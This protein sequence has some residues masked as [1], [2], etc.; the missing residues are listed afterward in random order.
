MVF[1]RNRAS[2]V[3]QTH[4]RMEEDL[5]IDDSDCTIH[6]LMMYF[7]GQS[8]RKYIINPRMVQPRYTLRSHSTAQQWFYCIA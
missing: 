7:G 8:S 4:A 2:F 6:G 3:E 5:S 1:L